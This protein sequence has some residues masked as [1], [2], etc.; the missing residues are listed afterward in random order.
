MKDRH[1]RVGIGLSLVTPLVFIF[2]SKNP[3]QA[4]VFSQ[5]LLGIQ[6]PVTI[7]T[8]LR[9]TSSGKVMKAFKNSVSENVLLWGIA[10]VM[11]VLN[12]ALFAGFIFH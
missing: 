7:F 4:M 1:T 2:F 5:V 11:T 9:L 6:L 12:L 8:Q 10:V 3:Y